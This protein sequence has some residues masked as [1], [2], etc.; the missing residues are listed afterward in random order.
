MDS[1]PKYVKVRFVSGPRTGDEVRLTDYAGMYPEARSGGNLLVTYDPEQPSQVLS[2]AWVKD[3]PADL[4]AYGTSALTLV[5]LCLTT[6]VVVRRVR[7]LRG[8]GTES[9][10]S[11]QP[12]PVRESR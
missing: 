5:F 9:D 6:A 12:R 11:G 2:H 4:P 3:P 1:K 10:A 7:I 8:S